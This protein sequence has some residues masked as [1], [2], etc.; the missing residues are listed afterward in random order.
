MKIFVGGLLP[1][2]IRFIRKACPKGVDLRFATSADNPRFWRRSSRDCDYCVVIA[3]F[4]SHTHCK[5]IVAGGHALTLHHGGLARLKELLH[6]LV[7][8][9]SPE[10]KLLCG[11]LVC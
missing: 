8:Q 6:R 4:V 5:G 1:K 3:D 10:Q 2:Q 9:N 7:Q 11:K